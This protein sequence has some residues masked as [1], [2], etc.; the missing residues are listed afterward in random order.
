MAE[1][2]RRTQALY[3]DYLAGKTGAQEGETDAQEGETGA[4]GGEKAHH[5]LHT[6]YKKVDVYKFS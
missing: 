2:D 6:A 4:Q 3:K 1:A 5:L